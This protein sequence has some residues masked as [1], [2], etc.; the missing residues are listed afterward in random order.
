M[1]VIDYIMLNEDRHLRNFGVI[2]NVETLDWIKVAPIYDTGQSLQSQTD[3]FEMNFNSGN[4]KFFT[5]KK[6]PYENIIRNVDKLERF[7]FSILDEVIDTWKSKM[8]KCNKVCPMSI[9]RID[10]IVE[11]VK[12]RVE[13]I[14]ELQ[15]DIVK[16]H[17]DMIN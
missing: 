15:K 6:E 17:D 4:G 14:I 12:L 3:Y 9:E 13:K 2:R 11:G 10:R 8:M 16:Q 7:D 5:N 1:L